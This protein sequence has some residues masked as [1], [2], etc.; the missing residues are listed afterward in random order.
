MEK[1]DLVIENEKLKGKVVVDDNIE[2]LCNQVPQKISRNSR[3]RM[4]NLVVT[5]SL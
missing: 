3:I 1:K 2:N 5:L 4:K